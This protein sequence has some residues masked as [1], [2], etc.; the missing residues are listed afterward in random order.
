M[1]LIQTS[2]DFSEFRELFRQY[3]REENFTSSGLRALFNYLDD[4]DIGD[5]EM[6]VIAFCCEYSENTIDELIYQ[7]AIDVLDC[8]GET[9][10]EEEQKEKVRDYLNENTTIVGE[11]GTSFVY[12]IF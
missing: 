7:Y 5:V 8:D 4:S 9:I 11:T 12:V 6:D 10:P 3:D 1:A 2:F